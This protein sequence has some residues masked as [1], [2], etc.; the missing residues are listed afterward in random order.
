MSAK[1]LTRINSWLAVLLG[2]LGFSGCGDHQN[3]T[4]EYGCPYISL[5]VSGTVTNEAHQP[6]PDMQVNMAVNG[7]KLKPVLTDSAGQYAWSS[8][9]GGSDSIDIIVT[10]PKGVYQSDSVR[11]PVETKMFEQ[12]RHW[13]EGESIVHQDFQLKEK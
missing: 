2:A 5:E 3:V 7:Y 8:Y 11:V 12:W 4:V 9:D 6:L 1:V 10:D 13:Q